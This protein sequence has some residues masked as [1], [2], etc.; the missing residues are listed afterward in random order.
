MRCSEEAT[1]SGPQGGHTPLPRGAGQRGDTLQI[2]RALGSRKSPQGP[3]V[4]RKGGGKDR[5]QSGW[6]QGQFSVTQN[7]LLSLC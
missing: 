5:P 1:P 7:L 3:Q 2:S 6:K 4:L